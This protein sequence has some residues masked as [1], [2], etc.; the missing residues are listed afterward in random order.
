MRHGI[1]I[2]SDC[3]R[4]RAL[5]VHELAH[6]AQYERLGGILP[7]LRKYLFECLTTGYSEAPL[8]QEAISMADRVCG[9]QA[10]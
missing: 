4:D 3:L 6:T 2:R 8:E 7:F 5:I 10:S 9:S 1:F